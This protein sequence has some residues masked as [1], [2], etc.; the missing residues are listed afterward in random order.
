MLFYQDFF[1]YS[2]P[3]QRFLKLIRIWPNDTHPTGAGSETMLFT[4]PKTL[5]FERESVKIVIFKII[6]WLRFYIISI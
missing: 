5:S 4:L 1:C 3:D 2:D 6:M